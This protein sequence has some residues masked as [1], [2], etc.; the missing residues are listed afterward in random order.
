[1]IG[2]VRS[3]PKQMTVWLALC[4]IVFCLFVW[5]VGWLVSWFGLVWFGFSNKSDK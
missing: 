1:M 4:L 5:L 3:H 2:S